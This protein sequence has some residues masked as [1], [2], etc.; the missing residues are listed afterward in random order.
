MDVL[1]VFGELNEDL[2][3]NKKYAKWKAAYI[4]NCLKN[5]ETPVSGPIQNETDE[6][7]ELNDLLNMDPVAPTQ[8]HSSLPNNANLPLPK[9]TSEPT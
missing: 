6:E 3:K 5:G 4:H 9:N 1:S 7:N 8:S 2:V